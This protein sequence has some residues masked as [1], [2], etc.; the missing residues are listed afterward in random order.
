[1]QTDIG[2]LYGQYQHT[3]LCQEGWEKKFQHEAA[4]TTRVALTQTF[5]AYRDTLERV[6]VFKYLGRLLAYDDN[7]TQPMQANL[8]DGAQEL[9]AG[10]L[11]FEASECFA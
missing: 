1:M 11:C 2:A 9:E 5:T 7:N 8:K 4:E 6:E 10:F 3:G